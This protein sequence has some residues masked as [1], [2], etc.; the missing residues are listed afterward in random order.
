MR[1]I[2]AGKTNPK[3]T[4][5]TTATGNPGSLRSLDSCHMRLEA[6]LP[7][8]SSE[9]LS[10]ARTLL[11]DT[12][13]SELDTAIA[14]LPDDN[15]G[16]NPTQLNLKCVKIKEMTEEE[17]G[18]YLFRLRICVPRKVMTF[19]LAGVVGD[20]LDKFEQLEAVKELADKYRPATAA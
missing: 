10:T 9:D 4:P 6:A 7:R 16:S 3:G 18:T 17:D 12:F 5:L 14:G 8:V 20:V 19:R 11:W 2:R 15:E 1:G 13:G